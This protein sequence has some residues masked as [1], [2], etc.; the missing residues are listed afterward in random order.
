MTFEYTLQGS[1]S[2]I[3]SIYAMDGRFVKQ[4]TLNVNNTAVLIDA[5]ELNAGIYYYVV[6][7][8]NQNAKT[9]KLVIVK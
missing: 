3:F 6:R 7:E 5:E 1:E 8:G 4:L 2:A 9:G